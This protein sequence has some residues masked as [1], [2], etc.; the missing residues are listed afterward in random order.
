LLVNNGAYFTTELHRFGSHD[1]IGH[2][3]IR[4]PVGGFL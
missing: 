2:V 4:S 3:N 1:V